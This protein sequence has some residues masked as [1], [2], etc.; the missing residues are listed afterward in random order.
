MLTL[1][2]EMYAQV[3]ELGLPTNATQ[4]GLCTY[5]SLA[6]FDTLT[7]GSQSHLI[8]DHQR[9][10]GWRT[11]D[12]FGTNLTLPKER[13]S[14]PAAGQPAFKMH[15][16]QDTPESEEGAAAAGHIPPPPTASRSPSQPAPG[17]AAKPHTVGHGLTEPFILRRN[18][19]PA[20][21]S[22]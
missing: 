2:S 17:V 15:A 1:T 21:A 14:K 19:S 16:T 4:T 6:S 22:F 9:S 12:S 5:L 10:H 20:Q 8:K 3:A 7:L 13:Q 18:I 11:R